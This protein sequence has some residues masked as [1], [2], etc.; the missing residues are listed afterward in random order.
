MLTILLLQSACPLVSVAQFI[1]DV[2][3]YHRHWFNFIALPLFY[4]YGCLRI[5]FQDTI[6]TSNWFWIPLSN[7]AEIWLYK[8]SPFSC[9]VSSP[10]L[11]LLEHK[12]QNIVVFSHFYLCSLCSF[13]TN[14]STPFTHLSFGLP[15][16]V[17]LHPHLMNLTMNPLQGFL[18]SL[19]GYLFHYVC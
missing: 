17:Y 9:T 4:F 7:L 16:S 13:S 2:P 10:S 14:S 3:H 11:V 5:A 19:Q 18:F 1:N 12:L 6:P 15:F 8:S